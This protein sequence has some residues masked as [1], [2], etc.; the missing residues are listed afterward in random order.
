MT[1]EMLIIV[2]VFNIQIITVFISMISSQRRCGLANV[3][4]KSE[5]TVPI[6]KE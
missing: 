3:F 2:S 5:Q 4:L 6:T 1:H